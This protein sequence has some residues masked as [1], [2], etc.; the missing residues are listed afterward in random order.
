MNPATVAS[1]RVSIGRP[2]DLVDGLQSG[3]QGFAEPFC[4]ELV[5]IGLVPL[6]PGVFDRLQYRLGAALRIRE[7]PGSPLRASGPGL[8]P[9]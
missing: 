5:E 2:L 7:G 6:G 4:Q 3:D 9:E 8:R 1:H